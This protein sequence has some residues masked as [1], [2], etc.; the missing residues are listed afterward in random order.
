[1][2][3]PNIALGQRRYCDLTSVQHLWTL[4]D[5][6]LDAI[7]L[8]IREEGVPSL[9]HLRDVPRIGWIYN[10]PQL[11]QDLKYTFN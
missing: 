5:L 1:M 6:L 8:D 11:I 4:H 7:E 2:R 10:S 9:H 3:S